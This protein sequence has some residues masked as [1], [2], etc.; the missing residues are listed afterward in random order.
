VRVV[1][2][3]VVVVTVV[4]GVRLACVLRPPSR[5][6]L[7]EG[8]ARVV[9]VAVVRGAARRARGMVAEVCVCEFGL[10]EVEIGWLCCKGGSS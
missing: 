2:V 10:E 3:V 6:V 4:A 1:L 7:R 8:R 5:R 9:R